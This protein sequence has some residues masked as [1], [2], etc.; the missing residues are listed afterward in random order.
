MLDDPHVVRERVTVLIG[1]RI[2]GNGFWAIVYR[3]TKV[4]PVPVTDLFDAL[5]KITECATVEF[6][7]P[8]QAATELARNAIDR[9]AARIVA[10]E[11][12]TS[13]AKTLHEQVED[14]RRIIL[15]LTE[16]LEF[17]RRP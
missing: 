8:K 5:D 12:A 16:E 7:L 10:H 9:Y 6:G 13:L 15:T 4:I 2:N 1:A 14:A 11:E 3:N 17:A